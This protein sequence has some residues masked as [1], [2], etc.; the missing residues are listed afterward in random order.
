MRER[1]ERKEKG[2]EKNEREKEEKGEISPK[3]G[4]LRKSIDNSV[5]SVLEY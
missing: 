5:L 1:K 3:L 4:E 2:R